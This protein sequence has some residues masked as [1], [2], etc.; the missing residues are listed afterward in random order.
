[1]PGLSWEIVRPKEVHL[2]GYDLDGNEVA[3]EADELLARVFQHELDHLDGVLLLE[4]L[5]DDHAAS[6]PCAPSRNADARRRP[7]PRARLDDHR[8]V[9]RRRAAAPRLPRARPAMAVPPLRALSTPATTSPS[10]CRRADARRGRGGALAPVAGQG[11]GARARACRSPTSVDD[12]LALE[13]PADLGVVVAFGRII[14]P[15]VLAALPMVNLH[16]S[17]LPRWRGA[18]PVERAI[19]AGD[20]A[21]GVVLMDVEEGLDTGGIYARARCRSA[22]TRPPTSCG[23]A[24]RGRHRPA[25]RRARRRARRARARRS[26]SRP[27]PTR[28]TRPSSSIDWTRP[29]RGDPPAGAGRRGVDHPRRASGSRC[30][31]R[32]GRP[33]DGDA[34]AARGA[35]RGQGPDGRCDDWAN[36][37]R[38]AAGRPVRHVT[39]ARRSGG[40]ALRRRSVAHRHRG[41]LRQPRRC[42]ASSTGRGLDAARPGLRHRPRLRHDPAAPACS[43]TSSTGSCCAPSTRRCGPRC[44]SAPTSSTCSAR[45]PTPRS[46]RPSTRSPTGGCAA[47]S[48]PCCARWPTRRVTELADEAVRLSLPRLD[49]RAARRRPR[50]RRRRSAALAAM[51]E[52]ATATERDDG[53]VQDRG[54][55]VGGRAR[56]SA[57]RAS[58]SP[59]CAPRPAARP[60]ASPATGARGRGRRPRARRRVGLVRGNAARLG[61]PTV[62]LVVADGHRAAAARRR[63]FDRVLVDAPCSG[64]GTLRRRADARWRIDARGRRSPR[65]RSSAAARRR[66]RAGPPRRHAR[67]LG[68][69]AHR[70]PRAPTSPP[71]SAW[72]AA[73]AAGRAVGAVGER[74]AAPAAGRRHRRHVP[75][76]LASPS[77]ERHDRS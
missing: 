76:S 61:L 32:R 15:H 74:R 72:R 6:R 58:G 67:L 47:S 12:V 3:L 7:P 77:A 50:R 56:R 5:D 35:A 25:G 63:R 75:R 52:P 44:A 60:P 4:R 49:R 39:G 57:S 59:T 43:T 23:P 37:A 27:T 42:A 33:T 48:T 53:Y 8:P 19:L 16:F 13:P 22:P 34:R 36:G 28:S 51:N 68:V 71:P 30:G 65:R 55:A 24:G 70:R 69:H 14:K 31:A 20:D 1:M 21:T 26:A 73:R 66:R 2:T 9:G 38:L 41:R 40:V 18:A 46:R 64:L 45:R 17:L 11:G 10:S 62:A 54:L 29:G